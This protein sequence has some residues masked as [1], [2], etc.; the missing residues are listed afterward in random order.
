MS[1][2][3]GMWMSRTL[4]TFLTCSIHQKVIFFNYCNISLLPFNSNGLYYDHTLQVGLRIP[5]FWSR[6]KLLVPRMIDLWWV[7]KVEWGPCMQLLTFLK[8]ISRMSATW[9]GAIL[10]GLKMDLVWP[11]QIRS[12]DYILRMDLFLRIKLRCIFLFEGIL[13]FGI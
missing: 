8:L 5:N 13:P 1:S 11:Y 4:W 3:K 7:V 10:H 9:E 2:K 6:Y 12:S